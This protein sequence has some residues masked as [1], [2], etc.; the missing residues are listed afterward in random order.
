MRN[1]ES[2]ARL[3]PAFTSSEDALPL[4][5]QS[6]QPVRIA[7][8]GSGYVGLVAAVCFAEMGHEVI[9]VDN[10][11]R[12]VDALKGGD[13]LIHE[14][15]LPELLNRYRNTRVLFMTDLAEATRECQA[16]FIAVG[17]PQSE[18]G[19]ADLS[20]VEAVASEIARSLTSYKVIVEKST[21]P[22]YTNEWI[23][24]VIER[25][26][27]HRELF[28]VVSN[29]EF[30]REG[31]AVADFLHPDRIVVGSDTPRAAAVLAEIYAPL[32]SGA[33]YHSPNAIPGVCS[34]DAP[35]P[36]L[37][38]STKSAEIIK[39]ASNAF[40]ALKISF[41][42]AVANLCEAADANVEQVARGMGLDRRI[43]SRFLRPGIGYGG[44]CFPKDVA[45][46][47]SVAE[48]MGVDFSILTE[49]EKINSLQ[50]KRFL[51]KVR[52]ALWTLRG[53]RLAVLGLAF[54][55]ET[56]DIRESP[57]IEMVKMLL[58]EGCSIAA[59]DPA[60][61][62]RTKEV[63]P[64]APNLIYTES[65]Y[66]AAKDADALL[67]LTDWQEFAELDLARMHKALRYAIV[68]DGRN[69]YD[70][71]VMVQHGFTYM[72][73]GRSAAAPVRELATASID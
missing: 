37:N 46:F 60:A 7:V 58:A 1:H 6:A 57:A 55:G 54:K 70:P 24:R 11:E 35:P 33:Y 68:I 29:P 12:K 64:P 9:C 18:T 50:R 28:D 20:Y 27:V 51:S 30:L 44:S 14:L 49:V 32:T 31:T 61:M 63:L 15:H 38:T 16:I 2:N 5:P 67:I 62:G 45:A 10:D 41:I 19:D 43:G 47:R 25:N 53:K 40:L 65:S 59:F 3:V 42:N 4:V 73:I 52:S 48:Q 56:D 71:Q 36:L 21:V 39:H 23:R 66:D 34:A 69:L 26:G 17:T 13:T 22:V 72:S 8:V